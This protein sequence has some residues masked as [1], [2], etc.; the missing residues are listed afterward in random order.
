M[1]SAVR[2]QLSL[3]IICL[4]I[5]GAAAVGLAVFVCISAFNLRSAVSPR[6]VARA[7]GVALPKLVAAEPFGA[8]AEAPRGQEFTG[9]RK[10]NSPSPVVSVE[11]NLHD[12]L[13]PEQESRPATRLSP[14][15]GDNAPLPPRRP[16]DMV[17]PANP[18]FPVPRQHD[19]SVLANTN[20]DRKAGSEQQAPSFYLA[21]RYGQWTAVYDL[22][23]HTVYL[24]SGT[25]LEAH[26]GLGDRLD[27]PHYVSEKDRGPTPPHIYELTLREEP[28]HGV[29]AL[30]LN[31]VG[32][33]DM[34]GRTGLLAH[35]YMLGPNGDSNGCVSF[36]D[37][38]AFLE[39]FRSGQVKR[40]AVV[41]RLDL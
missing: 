18:P 16:P 40:L 39:A 27:D 4:A 5:L 30:R 34:F 7:H 13:T 2:R 31:P 24:P 9:N 29:A 26:S 3:E 38:D 15:F 14:R 32:D 1:F 41:A 17:V 37:Y 35:T 22:T 12:A 11:A 23:A 8:D 36:K 19:G 21:T 25:R 33:G 28:F 6:D 20:L 10:P